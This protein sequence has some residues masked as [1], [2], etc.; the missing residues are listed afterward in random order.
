MKEC[1]WSD[2]ILGVA[3]SV[4]HNEVLFDQMK[5][6]LGCP[7]PAA[8]RCEDKAEWP[9]WL[10]SENQQR[11]AYNMHDLW[12]WYDKYVINGRQPRA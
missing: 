10:A 4:W 7:L 3:W 12:I 2:M 5:V 8:S 1:P 11:T 9:K 6:I